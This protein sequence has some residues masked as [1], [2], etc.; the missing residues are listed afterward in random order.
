MLLD[1]TKKVALE[2]DQS[3]H[4]SLN[5]FC[6]LRASHTSQMIMRALSGTAKKEKERATIYYCPCEAE[7]RYL[8]NI[9][10]K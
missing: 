6:P 4:I 8:K 2:N 5:W 1:G 7:G 10:R 9:K 3:G